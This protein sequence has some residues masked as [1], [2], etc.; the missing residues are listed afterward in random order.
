MSAY[1]TGYKSGGS[2]SS[3]YS[4]RANFECGNY[5]GYPGLPTCTI[6][7]PDTVCTAVSYWHN[8][9]VTGEDS[10]YTYTYMW[11]LDTNSAGSGKNIQVNW[12]SYGGGAHTLNAIQT[13]KY[14]STTTYIAGSTAP[15]ISKEVFVVA[16]P[17]PVINFN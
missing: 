1:L 2:T 13:E 12:A 9:V 10:R 7:G 4:I 11:T 14:G 15:Y 5:I 6:D 16:N 8:A 17:T 3:D